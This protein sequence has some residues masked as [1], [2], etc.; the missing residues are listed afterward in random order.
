MTDGER[1]DGMDDDEVARWLGESGDLVSRH[2]AA[3]GE[4]VGRMASVNADLR[5]E[6]RKLGGDLLRQQR[7]IAELEGAI[8]RHIKHGHD[9]GDELVAALMARDSRVKGRAK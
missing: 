2:A 4:H 8:E 7:R 1:R 9:H 5:A 3:V 6:N